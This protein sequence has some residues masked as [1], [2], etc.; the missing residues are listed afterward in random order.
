MGAKV[1]AIR[2]RM[3]SVTNTQQITRA[4]ELIATTRIIRAQAR[5]VRSRPFAR[6]I[7]EMVEMLAG[8]VRE[9]PLLAEREIKKVGL[10]AITSDRGLCGAYNSNVLREAQRARDRESAAGHE[11]KITAVGRKGVSYF[12]FRKVP[13]ANQTTGISDLP[14]YDDARKIAESV[15]ED[16]VSAEIDRILIAYTDFVS[17]SLQRARVSPILPAPR[18]DQKRAEGPRALFEYEPEP[19]P[20]LDALLPRYVEVKVFA[21]LLESAASEHA[22]RRRA[23]KEATDNAEDLLKLLRRDRD[24]QRQAEITSELADIVGAAEAQR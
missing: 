24:R 2:Q 11:V 12:R 10:I 21:A 14:R 13:V 17:A 19:G 5:T 4:M 9:A 3:R 15:I 7:G 22:A 16:Y 20:L 18:P 6:A 23:M 8:E 1:R